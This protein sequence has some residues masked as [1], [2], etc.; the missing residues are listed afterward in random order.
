MPYPLPMNRHVRRSSS[1]ASLNRGNHSRGTSNVRPSSSVRIIAS[2]LNSTLVALG[3]LATYALVP[4]FK[5]VFC[6]FYRHLTDPSYFGSRETSRINQFHRGKPKLSVTISLFNVYMW[7]LVSFPA[8]KEKPETL[9][10]K[11]P[12]HITF[13]PFCQPESEPGDYSVQR[14]FEQVPSIWISALDLLL[15]A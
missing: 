9:N 13:Y 12:L 14:S 6:M 4:L 2:S 8:E 7:W 11:Q 10:R 15:I 3:S 5:E 1:E